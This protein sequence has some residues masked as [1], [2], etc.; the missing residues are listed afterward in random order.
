MPLKS[1]LRAGKNE[2]SISIAPA[3]LVAKWKKLHHPYSISTIATMGAM[4]VYNFARWA[5]WPLREGQQPV[6]LSHA[7]VR[8][9]RAGQPRCPH[10]L[11]AC[12]RRWLLLVCRRKPASDFGWDWGP[13]FAAAGIH[14][15]V[16]VVGLEEAELTGGGSNSRHDCQHAPWETTTQRMPCAW[17]L[18]L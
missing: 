7:A 17:Q 11:P 3:A 14:G 5:G 8:T 12:S 2:L 15:G 10:G 13:A 4:D 1:S 9:P 16:K 6:Q 18:M